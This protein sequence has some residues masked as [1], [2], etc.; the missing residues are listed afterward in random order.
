MVYAAYW[1]GDVLRSFKQGEQRPFCKWICLVASPLGST[2]LKACWKMLPVCAF[3]DLQKCKRCKAP[4]KGR[5]SLF[6]SE[7]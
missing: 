7:Q 6:L 2:N 5:G 3:K 4:D 1:Q